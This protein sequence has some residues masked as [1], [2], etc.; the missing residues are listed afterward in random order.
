M[1]YSRLIH[2][3]DSHTE[4][5]PTRV[6]T[7]GVPPLP[8]STMS[9]RRSYAISHLE[10]L[11]GLLMDEPRGHS[12]M[13]GAI[14]QPP[15]TADA[16]WGV[17][18]IE[19]GGI[20]A[21]C[22][23]GTMGVVTVLIETGMVE[24]HESV[25]VVRLDTPAGPVVATAQVRDGKATSVELD[26]PLSFCAAI[27]QVVDVP[28]WG[29]VTYDLAYGGNFYPIVPL[30]QLHLPFDIAARDDI[31]AAGRAVMD[32]V[33]EQAGPVHP[34]DPSIEGVLHVQFTAPDST[35][36]HSRNALANY[37]GYF[38]RSPCGTGTAARMAQL[39]ARG[40]LDL[41]T[42]FVNE[43]LIGSRFTGRLTGTA[44]VGSLQAVRPKV[45]GRAW[46]TGTAQYVLDP[47]DP[48]PT[49]FK[50]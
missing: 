15:T 49:G 22:G 37:T 7:G 1:R 29:Q 47:E 9:Q 8:G 35:A 45:C 3:V 50:L 4:G 2:A 46:V 14:L 11:R 36:T 25:T 30:A 43:S 18:Y 17:L 48:F 32:A 27:D 31:L 26:M 44:Q 10:G 5:M 42:E 19:S 20:H 34:E 40:Q 12:A 39:H 16:D 33:N 23:H 24:V 28:G 38:D 21:M 41:N 6:V 13:S